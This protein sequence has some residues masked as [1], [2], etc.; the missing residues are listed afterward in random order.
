M[1]LTGA[2]L[3]AGFAGALAVSRLLRTFL[4]GVE[5]ID[6][7]AI[8]ATAVTL[9]AVATLACYIPARRTSAINPVAALHAE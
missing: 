6:P 2:G 4:F 8:A 3:A 1:V 9:A 5:A 7:L